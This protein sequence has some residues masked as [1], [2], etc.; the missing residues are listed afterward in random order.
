MTSSVSSRAI[1]VHADRRLRVLVGL[2]HG[3]ARRARRR[4]RLAVRA[5]LRLAERLRQPARPRGRVLPVR[6]VRHRHPVAR[7]Y[8]PGTNVMITTWKTPSG[9]VVVRDALTMGPWTGHGHAAHATAGRRRRRAHARAH[10][11]V[12]RRPGR[13]GTRLRAGIRLRAHAGAPGARGRR[14]P[15]RRS[16]RTATRPPAAVRPRARHRRERVRGRHMLDGGRAGATARSLGPKASPRPPTST[17]PS[18]RIER[19]IE[20]W[21]S[22]LSRGPDPRPPLA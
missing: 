18:G 10:G 16:G 3:R 12:P 4:G 8:E 11:R 15:H 17:R 5:A 6:A 13:G 21:R 20:F 14:P 19:T 2:P 1:T 7:A 9:W 22:W